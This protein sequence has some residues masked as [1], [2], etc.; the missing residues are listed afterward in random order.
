MLL[1]K[2]IWRILRQKILRCFGIIMGR[3]FS[4]MPDHLVVIAPHPDDEV[5]GC[6]GLIAQ[7]KGNG[8]KSEI[9]F[10]TQ[11]DASHQH[12][13]N[14]STDQVGSWRRELADK[15][16][17]VLG[18][19]HKQF[20]FLSGK[21]ANLPR[22]DSDMFVTMATEICQ[23][24]KLT[25]PEA[26]FCPH[27]FEGWPDHIAATELTVAA[28]K[29]LPEALRPRLYYYCVWSWYSMPLRRFFELN[30]EKAFLLDISRQL[31]LKR[32]AKSI[33]LDTLAPC[34]NP[35]VGKLPKGFLR[36]FEWDKELFFEAD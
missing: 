19:S 10:L 26:V 20:R 21:D 16:A 17:K 13:C 9:I 22:K 1:V 14:V 29:M 23:A 25:T 4:H 28:I 31:H 35:W 3:H 11:G 30:W 7:S 18:V 36:A 33:Y 6:A 27:P 34:G 5:F 15:A 2:I 32:Q 12:C 8:K 24:L